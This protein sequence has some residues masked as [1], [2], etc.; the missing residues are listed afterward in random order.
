MPIK[1][2]GVSDHVHILMCLRAKHRLSDILREIKSTSSQWVKQKKGVQHFHWQRGYGGFT[3]SPSQLER[4]KNYIE[5]Q[6]E[7]HCRRS[8]QEEYLELLK[9]S[10]VE[11]DDRYLW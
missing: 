6:E 8:F 10:G 11:Y 4:V 9:K 3:V 2:N 5:C 7:H 1:I